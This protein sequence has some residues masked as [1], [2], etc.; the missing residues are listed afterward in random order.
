[1]PARRVAL[2]L[3]LLSAAGA[4]LGTGIVSAA[5]LREDERRMRAIAA[6]R[7]AEDRE[8]AA[9][10]QYQ[11]ALRPVAEGVY[12]EVQPLQ[13]AFRDLADGDVQVVDP[14]IDVATH[15]AG[16]RGVSKPRTGLRALTPAASM[17]QQHQLLLAALDDYVAAARQI[18]SLKDSAALRI[19]ADVIA[20]ADLALD[21]ASRNWDRSLAAIFQGVT[22][23]PS[24]VEAGVDGPRPPRSAA[25]YLREVGNLC[26]AGIDAQDKAGSDDPDPSPAQLRASVAELG[27]RLPLLTAVQ[28]ARGDDL[29]VTSSIREP[30]QRSREVVQGVNSALAAVERRDRAALRL[31][32]AQIAR[33]EVAAQ[34]AAA[35][36][37]AYG[38]DVCALYLVGI[39]DEAEPKPDGTTRST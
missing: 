4:T 13:Q 5:D 9:V 25:S 22:P 33:G 14:L 16:E 17:R 24:P 37:R 20:R 15:V 12:D 32:R 35:G 39:E 6:E 8:R 23:P 27:A 3:L 29:L 10:A 30:L 11:E 18:G 34:K 36:F 38:S 31:A 21:A 19:E 1:M 7:R 2:P 28:A 26:S